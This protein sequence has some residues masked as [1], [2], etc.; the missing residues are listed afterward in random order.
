M[1]WPDGLSWV[2]NNRLQG[3]QL[4][5]HGQVTG[6]YLLAL[7]VHY[8]GVLVTLDRRLSSAA[9]LG[10]DDAVELIQPLS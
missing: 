4:L 5:G 8:Q 10:G 1:F 3:D 9:V 7:A 6:S 2:S